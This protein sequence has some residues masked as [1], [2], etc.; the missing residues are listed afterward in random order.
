MTEPDRSRSRREN[1]RF[2][3]GTYI[4]P[5]C[6]TV[7]NLFCGF[8]SLVEVSRGRFDRAAVLI[9]AAAILDGL[10]GRIARLTNTTSEFGLQ[11]DSMADIVSF[12]VAP[13]FLAYR[14]ALLPLGRLGWLTAFLFVIC[15]A[16]RLA[17]FN[18]QQGSVDRRWFVGLPSPPAAV[19]VGS[20]AFAFPELSPERWLSGG[21][22]TAMAAVA[23]LMV[24]RVRYRSFKDL[25]LRNRR[26]YTVVLPIAA[27][28]VA[29]MTHPKGALLVGSA[30]YL[31]SGLV[32]L[33]FSLA[34]RR[35]LRAAVRRA[36]PREVPE[37]GAERS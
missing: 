11:F 6:F 31:V 3:R 25:D 14:W 12:G 27:G 29:V 21:L 26:S 16:T 35:G 19:S 1:R 7:A 5:A 32:S 18:I 8:F 33:A 17:R 23:L 28:L 36:D 24:S 9:V 30:T 10:D 37:D 4:L 13:A 20:V 15:A 2:R 34:Q 22:A